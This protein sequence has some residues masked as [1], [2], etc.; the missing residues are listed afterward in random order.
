MTPARRKEAEKGIA[1]SMAHD[2]LEWGSGSRSLVTKELW[3][4][5]FKVNFGPQHPSTHGV[6]RLVVTLD[7]EVVKH[8]EMVCGYLHRGIEKIAENRSALQIIPFTDRVDYVA[9]MNSNHAV[10]LAAERLMAMDVP[11]RG[12][13]LRVIMAELNRVASHL[14]WW[15]DIALNLGAVT[16]FFY[17]FRE[18]EL[19]LDLF[20]EACG[21]RLTYNYIRPGGVSHDIPQGWEERC[22]A[23]VRAIRRRLPEYHRLLTNNAV[24]QMRMRGIGA[25]STEE[26]VEW[27]L[28]GPTL[29]GSGVKFDVRKSEPYDVYT[30]LKFDIPVGKRGDSFDRYMVRMN[31]IE[32]SLSLVEQCLRMLPSAQG[33]HA[34]KLGMTARLPEGEILARTEAPRGEMSVYMR[35]SNSA[36]PW[37]MKIRTASLANIAVLD[38]LCRGLKIADLIAVFGSLDIIV[39]E[40]DR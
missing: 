1:D 18:R 14:L 4:D 30:R 13:F 40:V 21:Q 11:E 36:K 37:R 2:V 24:F 20:E 25:I 28:S 26:A 16:P 17:A 38:W 33:P 22:A 23:A 29:R 31:E 10:S 5:D 6:L 12:Q 27:G 39:P 3:T 15:G 32:Q 34:R 35:G 7:G 9:A 19:I 8:V